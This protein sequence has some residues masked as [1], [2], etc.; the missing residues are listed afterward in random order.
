[1]TYQLTYIYHDCFLLSTEKAVVLFDYWKDPLSGRDKDFPPLL[2][3]LPADRPVYILVSHH[4]KDHFT[5]RIFL[6]QQK[7]PNI[8]YIIS[9][10]VYKACRFMFVENSTY[11]GFKPSME[12]VTVLKEGETFRDEIIS[13]HAFGST[14]IGNSY[15]VSLD[16]RNFFHA[17]DLNAWIWKDESTEEEVEEAIE[18]FKDKLLPISRQFPEL[19]VAMFPVD[20]RL[21][22]DYFLGAYLFVREIKVKLFVPMHFELVEDETEK[23]PRRLDAGAFSFY[24]NPD[25][26]D[27]LQLASTRSS[28]LKT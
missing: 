4:H 20:S 8:R 28:F 14:D 7:F 21:R 1:M 13:V 17:G 5:R 25:F 6:W 18:A 24:R 15:V 9:P 10:D 12:S 22:T 11:A 2:E 3:L 19:D 16:G 27:Y 26:G 23:L